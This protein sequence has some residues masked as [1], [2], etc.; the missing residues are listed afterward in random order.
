MPHDDRNMTLNIIAAKVDGLS[1][2][3]QSCLLRSDARE[4][5][6]WD[7]DVEGLLSRLLNLY[8]YLSAIPIPIPTPIN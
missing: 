8:L 5:Y 6:E 4:L 1:K 7:E 3:E 2:E